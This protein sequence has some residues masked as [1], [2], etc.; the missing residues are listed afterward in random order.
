VVKILHGGEKVRDAGLRTRESAAALGRSGI[1]I[2]VAKILQV[3]SGS[4]SGGELDQS[5]AMPERVPPRD[6]LLGISVR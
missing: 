4:I 1:E 2:Q 3:L 6:V 5:G